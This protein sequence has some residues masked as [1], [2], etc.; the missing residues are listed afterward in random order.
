LLASVAVSLKYV[1]MQ[2]D[3]CFDAGRRR[4]RRVGCSSAAHPSLQQSEGSEPS[5]LESSDPISEAGATCTLSNVARLSYRGVVPVPPGVVMVAPPEIPRNAQQGKVKAAP[6]AMREERG[7]YS[8][9]G[10]RTLPEG[11]DTPA[12]GRYCTSRPRSAHLP[13]PPTRTTFSPTCR[14]SF[15]SLRPG[16]PTPCAT[17]AKIVQTCT[18]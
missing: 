15:R 8:E 1:S 10:G 18:P 3:F 13:S 16:H 14:M 17:H 9:A 11:G 12:L 2:A 7:H 6:G 5:R 4:G